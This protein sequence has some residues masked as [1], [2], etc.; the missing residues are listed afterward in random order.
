MLDASYEDERYG[1]ARNTW[2]IGKTLG[3]YSQNDEEVIKALVVAHENREENVKNNV[4]SRGKKGR[5]KN[6]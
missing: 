5:N 3:L 6:N 1:E 2:E 4:K